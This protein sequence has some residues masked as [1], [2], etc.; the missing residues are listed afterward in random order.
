MGKKPRKTILVIC[1][2][3]DDQIFGPGG[4]LAKYAQEGKDIYTIIFSYGESSHLWYKKKIAAKTR[5]KEAQKADKMIGGKEVIFL[6]IPETKFIE[7][8]KKIIK[9]LKKIIKKKKKP[10][11]IFTHSINDPHKDHRDVY[12]IVKE[13]SLCTIY[14][15]DI[16]NP[17]RI[18]KRNQ[19]RMYVDITKTFKKKIK[20]LKCFKSQKI[21]MIT[22]LWSVYLRAF[23]NGLNAKCKF[24]ERFDKIR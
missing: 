18:L 20:A 23:L 2:H 10:I 5:V 22:L 4:T 12:N 11:K 6:G 8:K 13:I 3:P 19:P 9:Q 7:N 17:I 24:A 15:F 21:S 1:A 16:W 14:S